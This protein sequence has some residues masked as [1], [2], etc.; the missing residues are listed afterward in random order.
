MPGGH[1]VLDDLLQLGRN[2]VLHMLNNLKG[3]TIFSLPHGASAS[4]SSRRI[5]IDLNG[6]T[7]SKDRSDPS[8]ILNTCCLATQS[9]IISPLFSLSLFFPCTPKQSKNIL[10]QPTGN[11]QGG[12]KQLLTVQCSDLGDV[13]FTACKTHGLQ[14]K[15]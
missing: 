8:A 7:C 1:N 4:R 14:T 9:T 6:Y 5:G 12:G 13:E 11:R 15:L 3:F 2:S 10:P